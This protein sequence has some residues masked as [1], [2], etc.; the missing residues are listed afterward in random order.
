MQPQAAQGVWQSREPAR[1]VADQ[2]AVLQRQRVIKAPLLATGLAEPCRM[3]AAVESQ[4]G[5]LPSA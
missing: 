1:P 4:Q 3:D 5:R 2:N